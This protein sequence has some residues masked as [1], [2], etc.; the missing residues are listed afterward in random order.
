MPG[1]AIG[2]WFA[3]PQVADGFGHCRGG[4]SGQGFGAQAQALSEQ[5]QDEE[6]GGLRRR[7]DRG[8]RLGNAGKD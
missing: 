5:L 4:A 8:E 2:W 1:E 3:H 6:G 7:N